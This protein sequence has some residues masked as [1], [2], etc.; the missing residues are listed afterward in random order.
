[1]NSN[2]PVSTNHNCQNQGN[3]WL[4]CPFW[5]YLLCKKSVL[6][7]NSPNEVGELWWVRMEKFGLRMKEIKGS[8][9]SYLIH[10]LA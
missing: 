3:G 6:E 10:D 1:M 4:Q 5:Y 2:E 8:Q 9:P 7:H